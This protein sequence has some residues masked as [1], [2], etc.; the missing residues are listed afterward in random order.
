[1]IVCGTDFSKGAAEAGR[2]AAAM[3]QKLDVSLKLVHVMEVTGH[4]GPREG[5][6]S[7]VWQRRLEQEAQAIQASS[8]VVVDPVL[9]TG[10]PHR[11]LVEYA[12]E[13]MA[14][15]TVLAAVGDAKQHGW[16]LGTVAER[17]AQA[18]SI[19]VLIVRESDSIVAW[20]RGASTL[21]T[22][23]GVETSGT[24]RA[25]LRWAADLQSIGKCELLPVHIAWPAGEHAR[26]GIPGPVA[27]DCLHPEL[28]NILLRD[29]AD[30][31]GDAA[32]GAVFT[33]YAGWGRIDVHLSLAA[34]QMNAD[35]LVVGT[36]QRAGVARLWQGSVSRG[37]L[38]GASCNVVCVPAPGI[39]AESIAGFRRVLI[40]TDFSALGNRAV[41]AGYGV[42]DEGGVV[43]LAHVLESPSDADSGKTKDRLRDLIP[44]AAS[45]RRILTEIHVLRDESAWAG[46][47]HAA[48]R[49]GADAIC[50][51]THGRSGLLKTVLG[52]QAQEVVARA[53][54]PVVLVPPEREG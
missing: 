38:H 31:A 16:L 35:L 12:A 3:A 8:G 32:R 9:L 52:S 37:V 5:R 19:P 27:L 26:F 22:V 36:H 13:K 53:R 45:G 30:W 34:S 21:R 28:K 17:V 24:S 29:L 41:A 43:Y 25:A 15:L 54:I 2:A 39:A 40:P 11:K 1:M 48:G 10:E 7:G 14:R 51:S 49:L 42:V 47:W 23:V 20:A 6:E 4:D 33:V 44:A 18:S 50:M 46:I